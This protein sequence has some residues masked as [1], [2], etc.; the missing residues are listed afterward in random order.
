M[1][2]HSCEGGEV[3]LVL[4]HD[5]VH[6]LLSCR[7]GLSKGH[8][9]HILLSLREYHQENKFPGFGNDLTA[10][11]CCN[12]RDGSR[13]CYLRILYNL[14]PI[15]TITTRGID[16]YT[17]CRFHKYGWPNSTSQISR[18]SMSHNTKSVKGLMLYGRQHC[19]LMRTARPW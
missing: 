10:L 4:L 15:V 8:G 3:V 9:H 13:W 5:L 19:W 6:L 18:G 1:Q 7:G 14:F 2:R 17:T 11:F 12:H 16:S